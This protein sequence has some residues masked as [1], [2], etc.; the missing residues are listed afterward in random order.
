[1]KIEVDPTFVR[2]IIT[3]VYSGCI[4]EKYKSGFAKLDLKHPQTN[5]YILL[6]GNRAINLPLYGTIIR[7]KIK[8]GWFPRIT[9][10]LKFQTKKPSLVGHC[11]SILAIFLNQTYQV[12]DMFEICSLEKPKTSSDFVFDSSFEHQH[13]I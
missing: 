9:K 12:G 13:N 5:A 3:F 1:M 2:P 4:G 11:L 7:G 10:T 8:K 6:R